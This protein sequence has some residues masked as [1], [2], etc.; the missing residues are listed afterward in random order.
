[1]KQTVVV[2]ED[3]ADIATLVRHHLLQAGFNVEVANSGEKVLPLARKNNPALFLLDIMVPG[4]T[5]LEVCRQIRESPDLA[6]VPI[7]FLTAKTGEDD[8]V[9]GLELG[10]DDYIGKPF[11]TRE[12]VARVRAVL[13]RF[14]QPLTTNITMPD[15]ELN[16]DSVT[17][18]VKGKP[19]DVTATEFRLLHFLAS[20]PG[21]VFSRDQVL[22]AVWR[23]MSFVTPRSVDVYIRRLREKIEHDPEDPRYLVTVRG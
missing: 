12:L 6:K 8:R 14:D 21:R 17:L 18:T 9:K 22:D 11:S 5:G 19:V 15:W 1:M 20:H 23:D 7:I 13:R 2:L 4:R 16:S 3:D 10:A